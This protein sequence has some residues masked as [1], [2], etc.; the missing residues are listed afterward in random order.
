[1]AKK[2]VDKSGKKWRIGKMKDFSLKVTNRV[3]NRETLCKM[4]QIS[5]KR[6]N[7][8]TKEK[9]WPLR[10]RFV[11]F[12]LSR[13]LLTNRGVT[14]RSMHCISIDIYPEWSP[15]FCTS[16]SYWNYKI[17]APLQLTKIKYFLFLLWRVILS[18]NQR[19]L[20]LIIQLGFTSW[21]SM[22]SFCPKS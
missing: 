15:L 19:S 21:D 8:S 13:N 18:K 17:R 5:R 4:Y 3:K 9:L 16:F 2:S 7:L 22:E 1:M 14:N 12:S 10:T 11:T 20:N 6:L